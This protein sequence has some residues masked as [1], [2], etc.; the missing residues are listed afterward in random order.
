MGWSLTDDR[1]V[2]NK[3]VFPSLILNPGEFILVYASEKDRR[4]AGGGNLL[5]ANFKLNPFGEYLALLSPEFPPRAATEFTNQYPEQRKDYSYGLDSTNGWRYFAVPTPAASNGDSPILGI[6]AMPHFTV[7]RG[8]FDAPFNLL[9]TTAIPGATLYY[10]LDGSEPG[11]ATGLVYSGP[12]NINKTTCVR[13]AAFG[14]NLLP[15]RVATHTYIYL[16]QVVDQSAYPPGFPSIWGVNSTFTAY[17]GLVPADYEMDLDPLRVDPNDPFSAVDPEKLARFKQGMRELP[18]VSI[19]MNV[20]DM[21]GTNSLHWKATQ[22]TPVIEKPCSVEMIL[23]DGSTAFVADV[24]IRMHGNASREPPKNPKHGFKLKFKGDFGESSLKYRLFEDSA[25]EDYDDLLL[26]SDFNSSW[27]HWSDSASQG[28]GA[29]QRS[30]ATRTRYAWAQES[31]R[32]L[33]HVSPH[34]RY[35]HLF[36]NGL[37]WGTYDFSEQPTEKFAQ[38]HVSSAAGH[39]IY[40]QGALREGTSTAYNAMRAVSNLQIPANYEL[41]KQY[42]DVP[43]HIDYLLFHFFIGHQD[44]GNTKNWYAIR[45]RAPAPLGRFRYVPW[46]QECILLNDNINRVTSTD[47]PSGLHTKLDDSPQY[48]LDFADRVHKHMIAPDGVLNSAANIARWQKWQALL[49]KPIVAESMR[50]GDYRRDVHPYSEGTYQLYTRENQ[51]MTENDRLVNS[52][53]VGRNA[54]VLSQLR[55]AGFY[56]T[57]D[58]PEYRESTVAGP[59]LGSRPVPAGYAVA[60]TAT[61][62]T[63][64]YTT[65]GADPRVAYSGDLSPDAV[66]YSSPLALN[67]TVTLKSRALNG[68]TWTALNEATFSVAELGVPLRFSEIM[69]N[70]VGGDAYEFVEV[71]NVGAVPVDISGFSFEGIEFIFPPASILQPGAVFLVASSANT[72]A[73]AA[74]YPGLSAWGFFR[75]NL[76]NAGERLAIVNRNG[77]PV[78]AVYYDDE[79]G[80]PATADGLGYSLENTSPRGDLQAPANW[81]ASAAINGTPG[82]PPFETVASLACVAERS[83]GL[84][85]V[86]RVER[87]RFSGLDRTAKHRCH[88]YRPGELE[89]LRR[90]QP[91]QIRVPGRH[92]HYQWRLPRGVVRLRNG[93]PGL[94]AGFSLDNDGETLSLFDPA[95]N[96]VDALTYG[97]QLADYSVGPDG[98][99]LAS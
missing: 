63:I 46:D 13:A 62:G 37:Y 66:L 14:P 55:S 60:I 17:G 84:Q 88:Q 5:H 81:R 70:P 41:I 69:Y 8:F 57:I 96:R 92:H 72:N 71:Q 48:R 87:R 22:K 38:N 44:W 82:F 19:V 73:F 77:D 25:A 30:R 10:T 47:V 68:T 83:H 7:T 20:D 86:S 79:A 34:N 61:A 76:A 97:I 31:M 3:W 89:P 99:R 53:F 91:P 95:S 26:R 33:G 16:D 29:L 94:H 35:C 75:D 90:Q 2:P 52:Y 36:I 27:R 42:L 54:T 85:R 40:E 98:R 59:V 45:P 15:S 67:Q 58:A 9:L 49:D 43:Q 65:N 78:I 74:R 32:V 1:D 18:S 23:P 6:S 11:Q 51:W 80:W 4:V 28:L 24:G 93:A 39:D 50:W 21:F 12:I 56:P 64:Y